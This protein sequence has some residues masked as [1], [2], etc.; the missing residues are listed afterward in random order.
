[1]PPQLVF[2]NCAQQ[3]RTLAKAAAAAAAA[4]DVND[5]DDTL[6][7]AIPLCFFA[8]RERESRRVYEPKKRPVLFFL[9]IDFPLA[10][11]ELVKPL[12]PSWVRSMI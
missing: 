4:D 9:R 12:S 2:G 5:D 8:R 3:K 10:E 6:G 7:S 11:R 1:V